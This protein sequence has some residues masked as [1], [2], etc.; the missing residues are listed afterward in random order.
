MAKDRARLGRA[1]EQRAREHL[2]AHGLVCEA[3][4][5]RCRHG[6]LD[7]VMRD[8]DTLVF[9]E[10]RYRKSA[11]FGGAAASV[12]HRKQQKLLQAARHYLAGRGGR[13]PRARF[14]VVAI[15]GERLHWIVDAFG[16]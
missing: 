12:D 16:A 6:E 14:D 10:V 2:E 7:L 4:N 11:A 3:S 15:E 5:W 1:A 8:G 13:Q 9:V